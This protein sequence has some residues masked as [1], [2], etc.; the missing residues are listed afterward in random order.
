ME[1]ML[2]QVACIA[3][4]SLLI[5]LSSGRIDS[6]SSDM[7][8]EADIIFVLDSS[9]SI[10]IEN[11]DKVR[12]FVAYVVNATPQVGFYG[13]RFGVVSFGNAATINFNL[14]SFNTSTAIIAA[15]NQIPFKDE[16]TN[17]SGGLYLMMDFMFTTPYGSRPN[18]PHVAVVITD[19]Q[20][21]Y[22]HNLTIP[23]AQEAKAKG[24]T[25]VAIGVGSETDPAEL[26]AIA[27][28]SLNGTPIVYNVSNYAVLNTL[29][30]VITQVACD[31]P[32]RE[33]K[34]HHLR[35]FNLILTP[36]VKSGVSFRFSDF[37]F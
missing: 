18:V 1:K 14:S 33:L 17:T 15:V 11:W 25:I 5:L 34:A 26:N 12:S 37:L 32:V 4:S 10:K 21:T 28:T 30:D 19:G 29:Q 2:A 9:G 35:Q 23:Y 16:N 6:Q 13:T 31:P 8:Q 20:S 27:S 3:L 7:C 22:D 24:I 36:R